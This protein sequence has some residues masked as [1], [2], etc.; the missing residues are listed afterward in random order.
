MTPE[1]TR[2]E[3]APGI[4]VLF[5]GEHGWAVW[6]DAEDESPCYPTREQAIHFARQRA[7]DEAAESEATRDDP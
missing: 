2:I 1:Q 7:A 3:I 6:I 4:R 5:A